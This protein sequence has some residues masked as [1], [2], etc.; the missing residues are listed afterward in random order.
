MTDVEGILSALSGL[1]LCILGDLLLDV[2]A[3]GRVD[4]ISP[5]APVPIVVHERTTYRASGVATAAQT[6]LGLCS[7]VEVVTATG[8]DEDGRLAVSLLEQVGA[9]VELVRVASRSTP[10]K[11]RVLAQ[12][13]H[14]LRL[15]RETTR[16]LDRDCAAAVV[17]RAVT[18]VASANALLISDYAKGVCTDAVV[19]A[20]ID[21]ARSRNVPVVVDPKRSTPNRYAQATAITPNLREMEEFAKHL[22]CAE[23][24][25][26]VS[27]ARLRE[28][29]QFDW[30][31]VT[32]GEDGMTIVGRE[33]TT[34]V[35]AYSTGVVDV[36]GAGDAAAATLAL[37]LGAGVPVAEA[38]TVSSIVAG[39]VIRNIAH[40]CVTRD[41]VRAAA[42]DFGVATQ[43]RQ[44][45]PTPRRM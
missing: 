35:P 17:A 45:V 12:G 4:R 18:A 26:T 23:Q 1:R 30:V 37:C 14:L 9:R 22:G 36:S 38:A 39:L 41:E 33:E 6:A 27:A 10:R 32:R 24:P 21:A 2:Y 31:V 16:D 44:A 25:L 20:V 3:W 29:A 40:K 28:A 19:R 42:E 34:D 8:D 5:E 13:Q 15:D 43:P 7:A 11:T